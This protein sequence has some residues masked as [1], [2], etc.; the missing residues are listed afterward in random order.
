MSPYYVFTKTKSPR[1]QMIETTRED[2][3]FRFMED[4]IRSAWKGIPAGVFVPN[5]LTWKCSEAYC[6]LGKPAA[7]KPPR[8]KELGLRA[9][10]A[11]A[12]S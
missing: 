10:L 9:P 8:A 11:T 2:A 6:E 12:H 3:D 5:P 7:P 4:L 1:A